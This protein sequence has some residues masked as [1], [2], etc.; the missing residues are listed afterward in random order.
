MNAEVHEIPKNTQETIRFQL[1]GFRGRMYGDIRICFQDI[2]SD[3]WKPTKK[4]LGDQ[5][6]HLVGLRQRH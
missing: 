2:A 4:G 1:R 5:S 6:G 3:E